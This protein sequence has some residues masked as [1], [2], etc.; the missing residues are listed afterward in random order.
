MY[1]IY[2]VSDEYITLVQFNKCLQINLFDTKNKA[3]TTKIASGSKP[4][5]GNYLY[6]KSV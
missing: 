6:S 3:I 4:S 1:M 5:F 2:V